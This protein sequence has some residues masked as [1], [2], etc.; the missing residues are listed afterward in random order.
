MG[1]KKKK[2]LHDD[3]TKFSFFLL[4]K[5]LIRI[6]ENS[7]FSGKRITAC[8]SFFDFFDVKNSFATIHYWPYANLK[9]KKQLTWHRAP[10]YGNGQEQLNPGEVG[11][12]AQTPE[13]IQGFVEH[14]LNC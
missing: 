14:A 6:Y 1:V 8:I 7:R 11:R 5:V 12:V 10:E 3:L 13:F 9:E 4:N 2:T